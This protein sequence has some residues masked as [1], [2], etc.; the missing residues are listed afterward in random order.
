M[1]DAVVA[2]LLGVDLHP[3]VAAGVAALGPQEMALVLHAQYVA[4]GLL[5]HVDLLGH[6]LVG[7]A[8]EAVV[9]EGMVFQLEPVLPGVL[10]YLALGLFQHVFADGE[11]GEFAAHLDGLVHHLPQVFGLEAVVHGDGDDLLGV[12]LGEHQAV[13]RRGGRGPRGGPQRRE[14]HRVA[15]GLRGG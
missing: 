10:Q 7:A 8:V 12:R 5:L 11:Y 9:G 15:L 1:G 2:D 14:G 4:Q 3:L 13:A 6:L